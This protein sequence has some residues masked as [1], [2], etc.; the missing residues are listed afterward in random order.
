MVYCGMALVPV[1][2]D[3]LSLHG[4]IATHE[5]AKILNELIRASVRVAAILPTQVNQRLQMTEVIFKSL[6]TFADRT[7]IHILPPIRTD[8]SVAKATKQR[9]FLQDFDPACKAITDYNSAFDEV[10]TML[11]EPTRAAITA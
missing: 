4:A 9:Q 5:L 10:L 6:R 7:G 2:M 1:D 11:E 3:P 8:T